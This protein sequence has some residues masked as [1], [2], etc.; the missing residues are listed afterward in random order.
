MIWSIKV[1]LD[2]YIL[3]LLAF[4]LFI[5]CEENEIPT[6]DISGI[7]VHAINVGQGDCTLIISP[8]GKTILIDAGNVSRGRTKVV[9]YLRSLGID[10]LQYIMVSHFHLDHYGGL[11]EVLEEIPLSR[12]AFDHGRYYPNG[13][14]SEAI[15]SYFEAVGD[16]R[17][18]IRAGEGHLINLGGGV[19][20]ECIASGGNSFY[21]TNEND[22]S[23]CIIVRY[24]DFSYFLGGDLS[25]YDTHD[26]RDM[27]TLFAPLI[28]QVEGFKVNHHGSRNSSNPTF[29]KTLNAQF[30]VIPCGR[31]GYGHPH[32]E[33]MERLI[34]AGLRI[35]L[36]EGGDGSV[37]DNNIVIVSDGELIEIKSARG[38]RS[39]ICRPS[40]PTLS[41]VEEAPEGIGFLL[42]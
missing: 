20:F 5:G 25:G 17:R 18:T 19:W 35:Y 23:I 42:H 4:L 32:P 15:Y 13:D 22:R 21:V 9:P 41:A 14:T 34:N 10:S 11:E 33:T 39:L 31:N 24:G 29:L 38:K 3:L 6:V 36:T 30:A 12:Y 28:G 37:V 40:L 16:R 7:E 1:K 27:E 26:Y 2:R 8:T